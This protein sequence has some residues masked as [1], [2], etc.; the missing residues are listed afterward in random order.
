MSTRAF[1]ALRVKPEERA[2]GMCEL[3]LERLAERKCPLC[4]RA[5]CSEHWRLDRCEACEI[6]SCQL[7]SA[8]LAIGYCSECG[9]LVC[10][11]CSM[12]VG[13]ARMC[14]ECVLRLGAPCSERRA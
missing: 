14:G 13:V 4:G 7:C 1:I 2:A 9:R 11:S 5:V 3:C 8:R 10:E 6:A 12:E